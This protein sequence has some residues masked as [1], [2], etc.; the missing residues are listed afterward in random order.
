MMDVLTEVGHDLGFRGQ[1]AIAHEYYRL[2]VG[3]FSKGTHPNAPRF[4]DWDVWNLEV[5]IEHENNSDRWYEEWVKLIHFN[6]GLKVLITYHDYAGAESI[7]TRLKWAKDIYE[8]VRYRQCPD[9]WLLIFGPSWGSERHDFVGYSFEGNGFQ[10][11][12]S[13]KTW[14]DSSRQRI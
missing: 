11:L 14:P 2:D 6:C 8:G 5:A 1:H 12:S 10:E 7:G 9:S 13:R 4:V 3:Y